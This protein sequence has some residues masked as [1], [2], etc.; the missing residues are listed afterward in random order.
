MTLTE[1]AQDVVARALKQ[2]AAAADALA[3]ERSD[4]ELALNG[5]AIDR[6]ER[7][8]AREVG[9]RVFVGQ[10]SATVSASALDPQALD[11]LA[12]RAVAMARLAPPDP[13]AG[14]AEKDL[15]ARAI[16]ALDLEASTLPDE[17]TLRDWAQRAG[18][19]ALAVSGVTRADN[20]Q[21]SAT[22]RRVALVTSSGFAQ[23][24]GRTATGLSVSAIAGA[25]TGMERDYAYSSACHPEDLKA[26]EVVGAD[27]GFRAVRR[28]APRKAASQTVTVIFD[29]RVS[30]SLLMHLAS[31]INGQSVAR[32]TSYL[33]DRLGTALF[34][35]GTTITDD[36]LRRRG[37]ASRPFDGEG[38]AT[39]ARE[40]VA[41]GVL[42][43]F[44]LD[45]ATARQLRRAPTGQAARGLASP[46]APT[47]S[48]LTM[49][50]GTVSLDQ[51]LKDVGTGFYVTELIG[52]GVNPVTGD[53]SRG[54][55]GLWIENGT[56]AYPVSEV[57]LAGNIKDMFARVMA[58]D[59]L[60]LRG[61][62]NAPSLMVEGMTLAGR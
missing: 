12:E 24:Y 5:G 3:V 50:A 44:V 10:S 27:A 26:P 13:F 45:L 17:A 41:D 60:E 2:G 34:R 30:A 36:P 22:R 15:L 1:L 62:I 54:A 18:Q 9:L 29:N 8:E 57:T 56:L 20:P 43:E 32:G 6:L 53:Y 47:V 42:Q 37:L 31:A 25:G 4:V 33:K 46:P 14:L 39:A 11:R 7:A 48:N 61:S 52:T 28:L 49:A 59:D 35:P 23:S 40:V 51:M 16:P 55:S 38:L 21:A 19:A 58:A